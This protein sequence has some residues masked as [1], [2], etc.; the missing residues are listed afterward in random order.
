[1]GNRLRLLLFV[2]LPKKE[3]TPVEVAREGNHNF[4]ETGNR[5]ER[6]MKDALLKDGLSTF[7]SHPRCMNRRCILIKYTN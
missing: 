3:V 7:G 6:S 4:G 5:Q 1:M 2:V